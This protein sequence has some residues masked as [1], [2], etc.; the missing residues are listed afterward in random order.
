ML[1]KKPLRLLNIVRGLVCQVGDNGGDVVEPF[2]IKFLQVLYCFS[3]PFRLGVVS[4]EKLRW[5][6][7][8]VIADGE[9]GGHGGKG[10]AALNIIYVVYALS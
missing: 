4:V 6:D 8:E 5:G 1:H 7:A 9:K 3:Q 10:F 2:I